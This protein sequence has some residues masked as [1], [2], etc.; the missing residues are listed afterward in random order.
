VFDTPNPSSEDPTL[1]QG[2]SLRI[3]D[4]DEEIRASLSEV[5]GA[6][7]ITDVTQVTGLVKFVVAIEDTVRCTLL[8]EATTDV[9][10]FRGGSL[11]R[12]QCLPSQLGRSSEA[13]FSADLI[14]C[15]EFRTDDLIGCSGFRSDNLIGC[16]G[17]RSDDLIGC[18]GFRS[19]V[20][21]G[22]VVGDTAGRACSFP[23]AA[24]M[25]KA[26][27]TETYYSAWSKREGIENEEIPNEDIPNEGRQKPPDMFSYVDNISE[28]TPRYAPTYDLS[29]SN[30]MI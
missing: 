13:G 23:W 27:D 28:P 3:R 8:H 2:G 5:L 19:C 26:K 10:P 7:D 15:S 4:T 17:F 22:E 25:G 16:S 21:S 1:G 29:F 24:G 14:G 20:L 18:S 11:F 9:D 6:Q 12:T 30:R